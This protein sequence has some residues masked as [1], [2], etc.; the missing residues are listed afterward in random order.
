MYLWIRCWS[1]IWIIEYSEM[2]LEP[3]FN[4]TFINALKTTFIIVSGRDRS[5]HVLQVLC[6]G[7]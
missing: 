3:F 5:D 6:T 4:E 1:G 7:G 2:L